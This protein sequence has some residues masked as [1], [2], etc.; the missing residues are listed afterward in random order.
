MI[1]KIYKNITLLFYIEKNMK[2][3]EDDLETQ[4]MRFKENAQK[5]TNLIEKR[6]N[7]IKK[8]SLTCQSIVLT[9]TLH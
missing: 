7:K 3:Y 2:T 4:Q 9:Q 8:C 5:L 6:D 1:D